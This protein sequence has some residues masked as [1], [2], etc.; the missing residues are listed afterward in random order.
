MLINDVAIAAA[1]DKVIELIQPMNPWVYHVSRN[2]SVYL[3]FDLPHAPAI[4]TLRVAD[5]PGLRKYRYKWN[6]LIGYQG[7]LAVRDRGIVRYF[8]SESQL[9]LFASQILEFHRRTSNG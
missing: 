9:N 7:K 3:K 8:Y 2:N 1:T 5:H 4:G 6:I